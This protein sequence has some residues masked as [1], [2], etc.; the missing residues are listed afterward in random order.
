M[1]A[2]LLTPSKLILAAGSFQVL[3]FLLIN[4]TFLRFSMLIGSGFYIAYY[5]TVADTPLWDAISLT[6]LTVVAILIGLASMSARNSKLAIPRAHADL[7]PMFG[8]LLPGDFR[9]LVLAAKRHVLALDETVTQRGAK[10]DKVYFVINGDFSVTKGGHDFAMHGPTFV[11]EVA[12]LLG[13][14]SVATT[15]LPAGTE[16][17][18]WSFDDLAKRARKTPRFKLALDAMIS[19]DLAGKVALAVAPT[20]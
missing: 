9:M 2:D 17:L 5:S 3:S 6:S 10:P 12:Y 15:V 4:Q 7:V 1:L 11:G 13:K 19:K 18:E 20:R 14:N 16:V 8:D